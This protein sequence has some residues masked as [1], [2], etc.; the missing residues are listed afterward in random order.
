MFGIEYRV[1]Q[2]QFPGYNIQSTY[3]PFCWFSIWF[4][5]RPTS[6]LV[7]ILPRFFTMPAPIG[8]NDIV[9]VVGKYLV[10]QSDGSRFLMK[11]IAFPVSNEIP[12]NSAQYRYHAKGWSA[13]LHQLH[14]TAPQI[15]TVRVYAM[16]PSIDYSDFF[17]T[18]AQLG[19]YVLVPL[20]AATGPGVLD[21]TLPAPACYPLPLYE[22]GKACIENFS[23][24]PNVLAGVLANEV[25]NS[26]E[27]WKAAPCVLA[28]ARDL[29][30]YST[31]L[32]LL[33][34]AQ[35][36]S[37]GAAVSASQAMKVTMDYLTC[38]SHNSMDLFGIN[39][40]SWCSSTQKYAV[41][42][43][44]SMGTY[45]A[46]YEALSHVNRPVV[47]SEMGCS[48]TEFNKDNGLPRGARDWLQVAVVLGEHMIDTWSGFCAYAYDGNV[49]FNMMSGG[50]W[51]G[52][53]VLEP[54]QDYENFVR[55]LAMADDAADG[56]SPS[57]PIDIDIDIG[58]SL[59]SPLSSCVNVTVQLLDCCD[60]TLLSLEDMPSYADHDDNIVV[61]V[62]SHDRWPVYLVCLVVCI[63]MLVRMLLGI[64]QRKKISVASPLIPTIHGKVTSYQCQYQS[65]LSKE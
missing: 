11:G 13:V 51:N 52:V 44:G 56:A 6:L 48:L 43:D 22:Y 39:I 42:D 2:Y 26:L 61:V 60:L 65:I 20:T 28:Y 21:R 49:N 63:Y 58:I 45:R 55:A 46:V 18:A 10:K 27:S 25:M 53:T 47:F 54:K 31:R 23:R 50:P 8:P 19:I 38:D 36:D 5:P 1:L 37:I 16:D 35:H 17:H 40:E 29:K 62:A 4:I 64:L 14:E 59:P 15:N 33:Y 9:T 24:Y 57:P 32:P 7:R 12:S 3:F 34:T 41:N 30:R